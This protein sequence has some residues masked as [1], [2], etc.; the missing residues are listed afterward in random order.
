LLRS[1]GNGDAGDYGVF[2]YHFD[3]KW[4]LRRHLLHLLWI[5]WRRYLQIP[6]MEVHLSFR[7][8]RRH[9]RQKNHL[10]EHS[11]DAAA[12]SSGGF[13]EI[14]GD[15]GGDDVGYFGSDQSAQ[16]ADVDRADM[17][18]TWQRGRDH[19]H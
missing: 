12:G 11:N 3:L 8:H 16:N 6:L 5:L 10:R 19:P 17:S 14:S 9:L 13:P 18:S 15:Y 7:L 2:R 1:D 4:L